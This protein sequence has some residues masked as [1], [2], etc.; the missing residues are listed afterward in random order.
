MIFNTY[1]I[2]HLDLAADNVRVDLGSGAH[3]CVFWY[4]S[5]PLGERYLRASVSEDLFWRECLDAIWPAL[6]WYY[7]EQG[8][9]PLP[10]KPSSPNAA[11]LK[12]LCDDA[13]AHLHPVNIP[14]QCD[15]SIVICTRNRAAFLRECLKHLQLQQCRPAEIVVVDNAPSN[16]DTENVVAEF[17]GVRYVRE[18]RPG[19]D[20]ARNRG[21][22]EA[23][24]AIVAYLDDDTIPDIHWT[25]RVFETFR[26]PSLAAMTGLVIAA[27]LS[28]EAEVIF[29]KYWPFNRGYISKQYDH[30]FFNATLEA[31]PP[32][33][34]IGAGA[35]MAFRKA[36]F[37]EVG[38]FD[39][40]LDA[41]AAGCNGDSELWYRI[42]ANGF[43]I[44][45]NPK[46]VV[47]HHHRHSI[48][49]L[50]GQLYAYMRG[51]TVAILIQHQRFGH[52]GN[53]LHL[54]KVVPLYYLSLIRKGFPYYKFQYRTLLSEMRG[55]VSGLF[56][57]WRH[58]NTNSKIYG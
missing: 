9:S 31:G 15:V 43:T 17:E 57:Y 48:Q 1:K 52:R 2:H 16:N 39:E 13:V 27:S 41:G 12:A 22:L 45:Y 56:Y 38:Y 23:E 33:W 42:L 10:A 6:S 53:L 26:D 47:Q 55:I 29:E 32:V 54:L 21:A 25:Y 4:R 28:T 36:I 18:D 46:A 35:N 44:R 24:S 40:R 20:I 11:S 51:F 30:H 50:K 37:E 19:L 5:I 8:I 58:R 49:E 34:E 7:D 14:R 3:Y